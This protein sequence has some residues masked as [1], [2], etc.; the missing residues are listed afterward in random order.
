VTPRIERDDIDLP[1]ATVVGAVTGC[2]AGDAE[3]AWSTVGHLVERIGSAPGSDRR[4]RH[5]SSDDRSIVKEPTLA[6]RRHRG[7]SHDQSSAGG[8][9]SSQ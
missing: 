2:D 4:G 5:D 7:Q 8:E 6:G 9:K 1:A 3:L